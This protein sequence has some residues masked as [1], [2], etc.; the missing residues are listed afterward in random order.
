MPRVD[1]FTPIH[2]AIRAYIYD[3][4]LELQ[5][6]DLA[7]SSHGDG[8]LARL[9]HGLGMLAEHHAH[10]ERFVFPE[11]LSAAPEVVEPLIADHRRIEELLGDTGAAMRYLT[12]SAAGSRREAGD[13]L[14]RR[15]NELV[16][17][18][19]AVHL[20]SWDYGWLEWLVDL[21][22]GRVSR[23]VSLRP[24]SILATALVPLVVLGF[25]VVTRRVL[26][27]DLGVVLGAASLVT[28]RFYVHVAPLWL[29]LVAVGSAA[30]LAALGVRRLLASG[31][32]RERG[33]FTAEPLFEDARRRAGAEVVGALAT[34][35]PEAAPAQER[36]L[37]RGGG[38]FGGG[39][40]TSEF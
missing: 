22:S 18:Y 7:G 4:G 39:G 16:A 21:R 20:G 40:A 28:L 17:F 10:E 35:A 23:P 14:N 30:L 37:E 33:G 8:V 3:L 11:A 26:L 24:L 6:A 5:T 29:V 36:P 15:F 19:L 1:L 27:M 38:R 12:S 9:D 25:G 31:A 34:L 32:A 13:E 2:K